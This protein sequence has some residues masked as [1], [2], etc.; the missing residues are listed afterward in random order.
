M[1]IFYSHFVE[2]KHKNQNKL[3]D[4]YEA[5]RNGTLFHYF[6]NLPSDSTE[7]Q[8]PHDIYVDHRGDRLVIALDTKHTD[9]A[10]AYQLALENHG[11][12]FDVWTFAEAVT[13]GAK[14]YWTQDNAMKR[15][16]VPFDQHE[17]WYAENAAVDADHAL[18]DFVAEQKQKGPAI[19]SFESLIAF[20]NDVVEP[21]ENLSRH[22]S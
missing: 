17:G 6:A 15:H 21:L 18:E 22:F 13:H 4:A 19:R 3:F 1:G 5:A 14:T 12:E 11:F 9:H 16:H 2:L 8:R 20:S 7:F 10:D